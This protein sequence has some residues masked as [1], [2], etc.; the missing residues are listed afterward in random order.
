MNRFIIPI[1]VVILLLAVGL[2]GC[3]E[4]ERLSYYEKKVVGTWILV[5]DYMWE[6]ELDIV[7]EHFPDRI[8]F[9][10]DKTCSISSDNHQG[11]W[12]VYSATGDIT[13]NIVNKKTST[14]NSYEMYVDDE[15]MYLQDVDTSIPEV[16]Y[17]KQ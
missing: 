7:K 15:K 11:T 8:T 10:H 17:I 4:S 12:D 6:W 14:I 16:T 1:G 5:E 3:S 13:L 9:L 2:S